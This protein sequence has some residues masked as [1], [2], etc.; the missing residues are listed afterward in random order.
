MPRKPKNT[1]GNKEFSKKVK[2]LLTRYWGKYKTPMP[3]NIIVNDM[4]D[5]VR[6]AD[7]KWR[8][9]PISIA[10]A[11]EATVCLEKNYAR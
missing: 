4:T 3:F 10:S 2:G 7:Y 5:V 9:N 1:S 11:L 8:S 6:H